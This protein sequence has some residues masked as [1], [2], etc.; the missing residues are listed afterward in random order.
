LATGLGNR[1]GVKVTVTEAARAVLHFAFTKLRLNRVMLTISATIWPRGA[2]C[3]KSAMHHEGCLRK[4]VKKWG[5][6]STS[7]L[8][9]LRSCL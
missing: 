6:F 9:Y 4:H 2:S 7:K 3:R 5:E 1:I 8:R